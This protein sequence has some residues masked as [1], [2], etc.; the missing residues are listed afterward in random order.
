MSTINGLTDPNVYKATDELQRPP[1]PQSSGPDITSE[2]VDSHAGPIPQQDN[3]AAAGQSAFPPD[4]AAPG[5]PPYVPGQVLVKFRP[6]FRPPAVQ[7]FADSHGMRILHHFDMP[8]HVVRGFGGELYQFGLGLAD[9]VES[10]IERMSGRTDVVYAEPN[11]IFKIEDDFLKKD[12]PPPPRPGGATVKASPSA[13]IPN[14]LDKQQWNLKNTGQFN[15]I[16]GVDI[17]ATQAWAVQTGKPSGQGPLIAVV[18]TGVDYNHPDLAANMWTN[19]NPGKYGYPDDIHGANVLKKNG[20]CMDDNEHGTHAAGIIGAVGNNGVGITG[21]NWHATIA[22]IKALSKYGYGDAASMTD[23]ILYATRIGA[24]VTSNS[25]GAGSF[26]QLLYD[27]MK[28]S[29]AIH[30]CA[31]GNSA[32]DNDVLPTYPS[33]FKLPNVVA[34]ASHDRNDKLGSSSNFG[35]HSV[36]LAAPGVSIY[37]TTPDNTY[38]QRT[39]TSMATPHVAGVVGLILSQYPD[40]TNEQ[41]VARLMNSV[42]K[43]PA[44]AGR[45][46]SGGR[47]N[48]AAALKK[49]NLPPDRPG[50]LKIIGMGS[51]SAKLQWIQTGEDGMKGQANRYEVRYSHSPIIADPTEGGVTWEQATPLASGTPAAPGEIETVQG[52]L[53]PESQ[54]RPCY[55]AVRVFDSVGNP[56][57]IALASALKPAGVVVFD[58]SRRASGDAWTARGG[59]AR[60]NVPGHGKV[61]TDSPGG[62]YP[63]D[64]DTWIQSGPIALGGCVNPTLKFSEKHDFEPNFDFAHVEISDNDGKDWHEVARYTGSEDW[65]TRSISL[66]Q[67]D[68]KTIQVRFHVTS[69]SSQQREGIY[70]K[71]IEIMGDV[72]AA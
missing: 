63:P 5:K 49:D 66:R 25:L 13:K 15:G 45:T 23:A 71:D 35:A 36:H 32:Q 67:Y 28:A 2:P 33:S 72:G 56:S 30:I 12:V 54:L 3:S 57:P 50:Q 44:Y 18:D 26:S 29:P 41:I 42:V 59:W 10:S 62:P 69:D 64:A 58:D 47:V 39:G 61:Y 27:V 24:R 6:G 8:A 19:P 70:V 9:T 31:A 46:I 37:S 38:S 22:G 17:G 1:T 68:G 16:P 11:Y 43:V 52:C 60:V 48:V 20:D 4:C 65:K 40:I 55:F 53:L 7:S 51:S 14:D 21:I 34:V